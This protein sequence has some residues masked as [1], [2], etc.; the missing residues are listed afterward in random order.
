MG[1]GLDVHVVEVPDE[2]AEADVAGRHADVGANRSCRLTA[3]ARRLPAPEVSWPLAVAMVLAEG[4]PGSDSRTVRRRAERTRVIAEAGVADVEHRASGLHASTSSS[5]PQTRCGLPRN[6]GATA[7]A[8]GHSQVRKPA[9]PLQP[10]LPEGATS[11]PGARSLPTRCTRSGRGVASR[12]QPLLN[13]GSGH[14]GSA[15]P[16]RRTQDLSC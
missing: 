14:P 1:P 9:R 13:P 12:S 4:L 2:A 6:P 8:R 10:A 11:A 5:K 16:R 7:S 3:A 15:T